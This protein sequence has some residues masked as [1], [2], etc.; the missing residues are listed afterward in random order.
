M[1]IYMVE[2]L[3]GDVVVLDLRGR[4]TLGEETAA[5]RT[6]IKKLID[7]NHAR[8]VLNLADVLYMDSSGLAALVAAYT[9]ARKVGGDVKLMRLTQRSHDL[10]RITHL[11]LVFEIYD[12]L[13]DALKAFK[14]AT[15]P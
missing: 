10:L 15:A 7:E 2:K 5:L 12:K 3:V 13:E 4:I 9:T 14:P 1:P 11:S 8:I 6:R